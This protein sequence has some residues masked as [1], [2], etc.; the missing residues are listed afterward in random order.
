M[1][2]KR[3]T[4][5]TVYLFTAAV[6]LTALW[7]FSREEKLKMLSQDE[8][9]ISSIA[10]VSESVNFY[11]E[12]AE[13]FLY[14]PVFT[15]CC[16][17]LDSGNITSSFGYRDD[18]FGET[19]ETDFHSGIDIAADTETSVKAISGGIVVAATYDDIGGNYIKISHDNGFVSYYGH[20]SDIQVFE[21]EE[22][23]AGQIIGLSG[24]SGKVTGPHLHF[25][26][27]YKNKPV[28]PDVYLNFETMVNNSEQ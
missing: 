25:G 4:A 21:G 14:L 19:P 13:V 12:T 16:L 26:L 5:I 15:E 20:L 17:P 1:R 7:R 27:Y 10:V 8:D 6:F 3:K 23:S 24:E 11:G 22:V 28:D 9:R 18:P 2:I